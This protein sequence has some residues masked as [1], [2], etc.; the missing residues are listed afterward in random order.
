MGRTD[1]RVRA[2]PDRPLPDASAECDRRAR[3]CSW[4]AT[5]RTR[6]RTRRRRSRCRRQARRPAT[7]L[8]RRQPWRA[9]EG[10]GRRGASARSQGAAPHDARP[11]RHI[12]A[13]AAQPRSRRY[14]AADSA[15]VTT[16]G[17][18]SS[19]DTSPLRASASSPQCRN[20]H[21]QPS[22]ERRTDATSGHRPHAA[23]THATTRATARPSP[24][25]SCLARTRSERSAIHPPSSNANSQ[26]RTRRRAS[27]E[28][29]T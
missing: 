11:R 22:I 15:N 19:P 29:R 13:R 4:A 3:G 27:L 7:G 12:P 6:R 14:R 23:A 5:R 20:R 16:R 18:V 24:N 25:R 17:R 10:C 21:P 26:V 28:R 9:R 1:R 8:P 2:L